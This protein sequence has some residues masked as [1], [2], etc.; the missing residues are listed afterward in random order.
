SSIVPDNLRKHPVYSL[1]GRLCRIHQYWFKED[2]DA[3]MI[4]KIVKDENW[5][6]LKWALEQHG[7][8]K[9]ENRP[10]SGTSGQFLHVRG[11]QRILR[12]RADND[13]ID[14]FRGLS[15]LIK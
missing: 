14:F 2:D 13:V 12:E 15:E 5:P 3:I 8:L 1:L 6:T 7:F 4:R 10:A 11:A 9:I